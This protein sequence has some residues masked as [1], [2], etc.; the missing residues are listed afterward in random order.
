MS[1][2]V[3]N[4][5]KRGARFKFWNWLKNKQY[6]LINWLKSNINWI[7]FVGKSRNLVNYLVKFRILPPPKKRLAPSINKKRNFYSP[8][9]IG[10]VFAPVFGLGVLFP[11]FLPPLFLLGEGGIVRCSCLATRLS[12]L[13]F[14]KVEV[15]LSW[16]DQELKI[17]SEVVPYTSC[18]NSTST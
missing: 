10:K 4:K 15:N 14:K 12:V 18:L 3:Q 13:S 11:F 16:R 9:P 8:C 2:A 6:L 5:K 7:Y 1:L 17:F